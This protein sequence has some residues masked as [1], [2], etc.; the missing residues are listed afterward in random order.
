M[1]TDSSAPTNEAAE[2]FLAHLSV[3]STKNAEYLKWRGMLDVA[4]ATE[5][6]NTE[7]DVRGLIEDFREAPRSVIACT[8]HHACP[9][10]QWRLDRVAELPLLDETEATE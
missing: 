4:L 6:R 8:T 9:C 2:R 1:T 3:A 5:R 7:A 10:S